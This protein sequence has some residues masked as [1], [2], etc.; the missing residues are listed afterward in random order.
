MFQDI[1]KDLDENTVTLNV[2][3]ISRNARKCVTLLSGLSLQED[4]KALMK[5]FKKQFNCNGAIMK[6]KT[7]NDSFIQMS[8]DQSLKIK[9]YFQNIDSSIKIYLIR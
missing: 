9:E 4:W 6:D 2:R 1:I 3:V 7:T 8:G 5:T